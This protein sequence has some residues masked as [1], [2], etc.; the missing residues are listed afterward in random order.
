MHRPNDPGLTLKPIGYVRTGSRFKFD[1]PSQPDAEADEVNTIE[2][3]PGKQFELALEDLEGFDKIWLLWWFDRNKHWRPRV[4]PPRGPAKRRGVFATRSS[5][6]PNPIGLTC[7]SLLRLEGL[8]LEVGPLDLVD[9]TPIFDI[10]P[11]LRTVDS[12]PEASLGWVEAVVAEQES[13]PVYHVEV[14]P[15]ARR[16]LDWLLKNWKIDFTERAFDILRRDPHPHRT[17]RIL[18]LEPNLLRMGCGAWRVYFRIHDDVVVIHEIDKG[19]A[20]D[21]L[22]FPYID[23]VIDGHAQIAFGIWNRADIDL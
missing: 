18:Q 16:Q 22:D 3:L 21:R 4:M 7:V 14:S 9:G 23:K 17:R 13:P 2:L 19:Y 20:D 12:Y 15:R 1:A 10:K 11:Y 6:R 8:T 5:H